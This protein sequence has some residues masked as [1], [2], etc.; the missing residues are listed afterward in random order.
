MAAVPRPWDFGIIYAASATTPLP[1]YVD[2]KGVTQDYIELNTAD[3]T[4][5][6]TVTS[7]GVDTSKPYADFATG[8]TLSCEFG[9]GVAAEYK[10]KL[11]YRRW[12]ETSNPDA[13]RDLQT[14]N[15]NDTSV[16]AAEQTIAG[17][18][19]VYLALQTASIFAAGQIR[20]VAYCSDPGE[21]GPGANDYILIRGMVA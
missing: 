16:T 21:G 15:Q 11:Q 6:T 7:G 19:V 9:F 12:D 1:T 2:I 18:G 10:L 13:W 3:F 5:M 14:V 20:L 17:S 8:L 4:E